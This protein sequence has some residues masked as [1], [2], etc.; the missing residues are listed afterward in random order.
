[1]DGQSVSVDVKNLKIQLAETKTS[2]VKVTYTGP[3]SLVE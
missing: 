3:Q 1:M 2:I